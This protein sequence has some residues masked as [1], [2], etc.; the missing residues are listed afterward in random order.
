[1]RH[2]TFSPGRK[3]L[4]HETISNM[5]EQYLRDELSRIEAAGNLRHLVPAAHEGCEIIIDGRRML[6]LSS[7]D[8]LGLGADKMLR[9]EF[10]AQ[11]NPENLYMSSSSSRLLSGEFPVYGQVETMLSRMFGKEAALVFNSGYHMNL[12]ILP[13]LAIGNTLII[14]DK[15]VHAS[16][17]D[18]IRLS[19]A[20]YC[21]FRHNDFSLLENILER[22]HRRFDRIIIVVESVYSMDGDTADLQLICRLKARYGNVLI[23]VDE[24]H[25]FGVF[26]E[27]GLG[28][29]EAQG[30]LQQTDIIC[31]TFGKALASVGGFTVCSNAVRDILVNRMRPFIFSTALPP[32]N[33]MWTAFMLGRMSGL[34]PLR[35]HLASISLQ[36]CNKLKNK[37]FKMVSESQIIPLVVGDSQAAVKLASALRDRGFY[38]LPV[39]PPTVPNG[40]SRIRFSLTANMSGEHIAALSEAIDELA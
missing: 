18:G 17:I 26:G 9:K 27:N 1:M 19:G 39:R 12:G 7:N 33:W 31:G 21:R 36:L 13:A 24:A 23:Y 14:A 25:A 29:A 15:L 34:K 32:V 38:A 3:T 30:C 11:L 37:G 16:I 35:E 20:E 2:D 4:F 8:Y 6:N 22:S 40:T 28:L 5:G 10:L